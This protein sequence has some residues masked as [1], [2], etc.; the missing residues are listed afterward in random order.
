MRNNLV[1]KKLEIF[2][3][4]AC[5]K[6]LPVLFEIDKRGVD[7]HSVRC[8]LCDDDLETVEH[9]LIF[10]KLSLDIWDRVFAWWG[11]GNMSNLI[12]GEILRG[13]CPLSSSILGTKIWQAVEWVCA[14]LIWKNRNEKVFRG[15]S[16]TAPVALNEIQ[17]KSFD[18]ISNRLKKTKIDW[19]TWLHNPSVYL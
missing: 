2:I 16:W 3:W 6:R 9:S 11:F 13:K 8:P 15:K 12:L 1:P 18:W 19:L 10:C 17:L 4:R 7:L 5:Q 14:Y